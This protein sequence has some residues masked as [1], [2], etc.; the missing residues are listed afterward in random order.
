MI[1]NNVKL[2]PPPTSKVQVKSEEE[3]VQQISPQPLQICQLTNV[4]LMYLVKSVPIFILFQ[5]LYLY[6]CEILLFE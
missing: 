5:G 3:A 4:N 6:I 2:S 1:K